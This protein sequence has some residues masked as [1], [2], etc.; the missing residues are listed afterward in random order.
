MLRYAVYPSSI[1][2]IAFTISIWC[3]L[4]FEIWVF[5]R[6]RGKKEKGSLGGGRW[7]VVALVIGITL[8]LNMPAIAPMF[9]VQTH[10]PIY[11]VLGIVL[12]WAGL[13][14]RFWSI[15]TLGNLFSTRLVIQDR[16]ELITR[17]S[18]KYLRNPSYTAALVTF[19]GI[20]IAIGNWLSI[21]ALLLTVV[22]AYALRIRVEDKMLLQAFGPTYEEYK[23]RTWALVPFVW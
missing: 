20:G 1:Y 15:Q 8:A 11:F 7:L 4:L 2:T 14:F 17:G 23:K 12:I 21:A 9:N 22:P 6:D 19:T 18:Y 3:W 13:L 16:H 10:F 5:S